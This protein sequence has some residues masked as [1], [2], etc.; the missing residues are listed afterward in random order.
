MENLPFADVWSV[1]PKTIDVMVHRDDVRTVDPENVGRIVVGN[2]QEH[3]DAHAP[4]ARKYAW[5]QNRGDSSLTHAMTHV[6]LRR[7]FGR[8]ATARNDWAVGRD[9]GFFADFRQ[10]DEFVDYIDQLVGNY[11]SILTKL[12]AGETYEGRPIYGVRLNTGGGAKPA[13]YIQANV[14]AREWLAP[15]TNLWTLTGLVED[16]TSGTEPGASAAA[17]FDWY[18]VPMVNID[19]YLFTWTDDRLWRKN[20]RHNSG[21]SYGVDINRNWDGTLAEQCDGYARGCSA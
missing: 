11:S 9:G 7:C 8:S 13:F 12:E 18:I 2:I 5:L 16:Y 21:N 1:T 20:R 3:I 14:H 10:A 19:G 15:T 17:K 6:V 4:R